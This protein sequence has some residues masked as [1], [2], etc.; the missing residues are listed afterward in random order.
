MT[1]FTRNRSFFARL[2]ERVSSHLV[3]EAT[4]EMEALDRQ[5]REEE[6]RM[7]PGLALLA[8]LLSGLVSWGA[9]IFLIR[10]VV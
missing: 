3:M 1:H 7:A 10:W 4:P 9:V 5:L 8:I 2:R 6:E